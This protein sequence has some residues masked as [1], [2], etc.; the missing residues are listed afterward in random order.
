M[1]LKNKNISVVG[2]GLVGALLSIYLNQQGA[3]ISVF[4]K[5]NDIRK[6]NSYGGRSI[7]LALSA[8]GIQ[9]LKQVGVL[10]SI[11]KIAMPMYKR[12]MHS[13]DGSLT[14]QYYGK[15]DQAIYSVPRKDLNT[16]L[17]DMAE[18]NN[19]NFFFNHECIDIDFEETSLMFNNNLTIKSDFIFGSDGAGSVIRKKMN[20]YF[21]DFIVAEQF[22]D[23]GYK[24]LAIPADENGKHKIANNALHIW[25]RKD[26]MVIALPNLDGTFTCTLFA[27]MKGDNSFELLSEKSKLESF[28]SLNFNNLTH[29]IPD[30]SDQY[31][32]NPLSSLGFVRCDS[33]NKYNTILIGDACHATVPFYGQ[34]MN[35]GFEDCFTLNEW[36]NKHGMMNNLTEFLNQRIINTTAMQNL[37]MQ[38]FIEMR[39]KTADSNFLLQKK[40]ENWFSDKYPDKW[41]PLYSMVS[42]SHMSYDQAFKKGEIQDDIMKDIMK[43]NNLSGSFNLF[44]LS[45]KDIE[46]QILSKL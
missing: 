8:R 14:E 1:H 25:P 20:Q 26:Y 38:N 15:K 2:G 27:P 43:K 10:D 46:K 16:R 18:H 19:V 5:R 28:F 12:I 35:S 22:I 3:S 42:F 24:E 23:F 21:K 40:I 30:L 13:V 4:E 34:G 9:A 6:D 41:V 44:E 45:E 31:F 11:M 36:I 7:N 37:S 33:W 32:N 29:L 17:I 39:G